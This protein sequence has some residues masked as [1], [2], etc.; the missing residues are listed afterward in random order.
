MLIIL[1]TSASIL[2]GASILTVALYQ[3]LSPY[4]GKV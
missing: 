4:I 3:N 1:A 2:T